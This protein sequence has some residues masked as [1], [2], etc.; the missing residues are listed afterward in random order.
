MPFAASTNFCFVP[1]S[2]KTRTS[3]QKIAKLLTTYGKN[4]LTSAT[5]VRGAGVTA[6]DNGITEALEFSSAGFRRGEEAP[7]VR[8]V[9]EI[10]DFAV[11]HAASDIHVEPTRTGGRVRH[12]VDGILIQ[13]R[14]LT[15]ELYGQAVS[16][17]KLMAGMDIADRRQP[18]SG[19]HIASAGRFTRRLS[20]GGGRRALNQA[21]MLKRPRF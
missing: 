14:V 19:F 12:R 9:D 6:T 16:R 4:M 17:M 18:Q 7:A 8:A 13:C 2:S 5:P 10:H 20:S 1:A 15:P 21:W 11:A 3:F